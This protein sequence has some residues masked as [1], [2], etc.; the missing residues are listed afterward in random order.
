MPALDLTTLP[1]ATLD[2]RDTLL[3]SITSQLQKDL[4]ATRK[5]AA[6]LTLE[7]ARRALAA[8]HPHIG[9]LEFSYIGLLDGE[10]TP[11]LMFT[12]AHTFAGTPVPQLGADDLDLG[13]VPIGDVE[14]AITDIAPI[15]PNTTR[16]LAVA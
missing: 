7:R 6:E 12:A 3:S 13:D 15:G 16:T 2:R 1:S 8:N 4:A 14:A 10:E 5:A 9:Y 11:T